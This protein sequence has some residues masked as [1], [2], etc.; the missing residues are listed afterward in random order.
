MLERSSPP[1]PGALEEEEIEYT[2]SKGRGPG[3]GSAPLP[4]SFFFF[5]VNK[6]N[7]FYRHNGLDAR[8]TGAPLIFT[9][10]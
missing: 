6:G 3:V 10:E 4:L 2:G 8:K 9:I 7:G 5:L 1:K